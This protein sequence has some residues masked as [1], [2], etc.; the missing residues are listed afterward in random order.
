MVVNGMIG[1]MVT[2]TVRYRNRRGCPRGCEGPGRGGL[3]C[4]Q[5]G[6]LVCSLGVEHP[7]TDGSSRHME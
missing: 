4:S 1:I 2:I 3:V 6:G 7:L 5:G